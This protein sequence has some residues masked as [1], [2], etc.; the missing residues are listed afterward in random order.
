[1]SASRRPLLRV[2]NLML[3]S[4]GFGTGVG[5]S[6][7]RPFGHAWTLVT[8]PCAQEA[9]PGVDAGIGEHHVEAS[10]TRHRFIEGVIECG[11]VGDVDH[12]PAHVEAR[13]LQARTLL[14]DARLVRIE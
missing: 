4:D 10:I 5:Q 14:S 1:M 6:L 13:A 3:S 11:M 7:E 12:L 2:Q 8:H 9:R